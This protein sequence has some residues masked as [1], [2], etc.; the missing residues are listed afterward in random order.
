MPEL[1]RADRRQADPHVRRWSHRPIVGDQQAHR[2]REYGGSGRGLRSQCPRHAARDTLQAMRWNRLRP[3]SPARPPRAV[4]RLEP[5]PK[6]SGEE[7]SATM[8]TQEARASCKSSR[9]S[10]PVTDQS[11]VSRHPRAPC[12][13]ACLTAEPAQSLSTTAPVLALS[14]QCPANW[15]VFNSY[16]CS[17]SG[18]AAAALAIIEFACSVV[19]VC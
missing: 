9:H 4:R 6:P 14:T 17:A 18:T 12:A 16:T 3:E 2:C 15:G 11:K 13:H 5:S 1:L 8:G 7:H 10:A 19:M